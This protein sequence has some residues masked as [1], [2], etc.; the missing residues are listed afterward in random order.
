[1]TPAAA[2]AGESYPKISSV[3]GQAFIVVNKDVRA[4]VTME[5][6]LSSGSVVEVTEGSSLSFLTD[7]STGISTEHS[8][9]VIRDLSVSSKSVIYPEYGRFIISK[10]EHDT[11]YLKGTKVQFKIGEIFVTVS[12]GCIAIDANAEGVRMLSLEPSASVMH[13]NDAG[14]FT[15]YELNDLSWIHL[16]KAEDGSV[17]SETGDISSNSEIEDLLKKWQFKGEQIAFMNT[18]YS[19]ISKFEKEKEKESGMAQVAGDTQVSY[20]KNK[21]R[22]AS[23]EPVSG[24]LPEGTVVKPVES[25]GTDPDYSYI[26]VI[27]KT[28]LMFSHWELINRDNRP[29][30]S[31]INADAR[32]R[33]MDPQAQ[34][35]KA[36]SQAGDYCLR[37]AGSICS[38]YFHIPEKSAVFMDIGGVR[39]ADVKNIEI[40]NA[41]QGRDVFYRTTDRIALVPGDY[42]IKMG[43]KIIDP[44]TNNTAVMYKEFNVKVYPGIVKSVFYND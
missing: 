34:S 33:E 18:C 20:A 25:S 38:Q 12:K 29:E 22:K 7:K 37:F 44:D 31:I 30:V 11:G 8:V 23:P 5:T 2:R 10:Q 27:N 4:S 42:M 19:A 24:S 21:F 26:C 15:R 28:E 41:L 9:F 32:C 17:S 3:T 14:K 16:L 35:G 13:K 40:K 39:T 1:M 43:K 36:V 6:S